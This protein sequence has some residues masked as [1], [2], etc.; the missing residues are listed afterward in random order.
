MS[1]NM[2]RGF[3]RTRQS[4]PTSQGPSPSIDI[5]FATAKDQLQSPLFSKI[6]PEIRNEIF[7]LALTEFRY[8][9][10]A[11]PGYEGD[12]RID[13]AL[14]RTCKIVYGETRGMPDRNVEIVS[15]IG[16]GRRA[17]EALTLTIRYTDWWWWEDNRP[18]FPISE[19]PF[20]AIGGVQLPES[21][22]KMVIEFETIESKR[23]MLENVIGQ[24]SKENLAWN[25]KDGA[26]LVMKDR[27]EEWKWMGPTRFKNANGTE[28][29]KYA[30][31]G[32]AESME[33]LVKVVEW[34]VG[35]TNA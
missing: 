33:M 21:V 12:K 26:K 5:N 23:K 10:Y 11:R 32:D 13:V 24:L 9:D 20:F 28:G 30:H 31:H 6:P 16:N 7:S 3:R 4:A 22:Q 17:P 25:R 8:A 18:I 19:T 2:H 34:A 29:T 1:P 14:L 15:W 35:K 27:V